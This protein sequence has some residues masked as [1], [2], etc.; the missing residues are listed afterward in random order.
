MNKTTDRVV[1]RYAERT[2]GPYNLY[3]RPARKRSYY[4]GAIQCAPGQ[5]QDGYGR[6]ITTDMVLRFNGEKRAYRV[7][8]TCFSNAA[9]YW[10]TR[11]GQTL[12]LSTHFQDEI[13][14]EN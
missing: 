9:S 11:K 7:Y 5:G 3:R 10:I 12:H 2:V 1:I 13:L 4:G 6:K 14:E 8:A